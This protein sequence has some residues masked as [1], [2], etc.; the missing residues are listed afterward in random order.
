M[1]RTVENIEKLRSHSK[2]IREIADIFGITYSSMRMWMKRR[3]ITTSYQNKIKIFCKY[4]ESDLP[5]PSSTYCSNKCQQDYQLE[6][7]IKS[8]NFSPQIA[9]RYLVKQDYSCN[10]CGIDEWENKV[11]VL[12]LDHID[13]NSENNS[14]E[15]LRLVCPNCDSQLPTFKA[16]NT[17]NG[18]AYRRERYAAGKSY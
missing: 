7:K 5:R 4:C 11:L 2:S 9:K 16:R 15:N 3:G 6:Q 14:L 10:I 13:G 12:I 18:R 17:G 8:G 1:Q